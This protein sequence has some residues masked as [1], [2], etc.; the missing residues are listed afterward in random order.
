MSIPCLAFLLLMPFQLLPAEA[1]FSLKKWTIFSPSKSDAEPELSLPERLALGTSR[2]ADGTSKFVQSS[3]FLLSGLE[4]AIE[5]GL[6][7]RMLKA[8]GEA[9]ASVQ[10]LLA[11]QHTAPPTH[12]SRLVRFV[13]QNYYTILVLFAF[14]NVCLVLCLCHLKFRKPEEKGIKRSKRKRIRR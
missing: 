2:L 14:L 7:E 9:A 8:E 12:H 1:K 3:I 10:R 5:E 11:M 6:V 13:G 4:A